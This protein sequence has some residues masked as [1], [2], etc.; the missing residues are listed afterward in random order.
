MTP[1]EVQ[2]AL[3]L[4]LRVGD[5]LLSSGAG[6][7]EVSETI[8]SV[9]DHAGLRRADV[10]VTFTSLRASYQ[11]DPEDMPVSLAR[12]V[13]SRNLDYD[14]LTK[15]YLLVGDFLR[16][17]IGVPEARAQVAR[18]A[19]H[20][21]WVPRWAGTAAAAVFGGSVALLLGAGA[22][23]VLVA[24]VAAVAVTLLQNAMSVR[25]WPVFYVQAACGAL[26]TTIALSATAL[27]VTF[28]DA[29]RPSLVLTASIVLLLA[30]IG[31]LG[32]IQDS[33][34]GFYV[35][36]AARVLEAVLAT[37]GLIA[38]V[39]AGLELAPV[40]GIEFSRITPGRTVAPTIIALAVL[41]GVVAA[42]AFAFICSA[43][44]RALPAV[45]ATALLGQLVAVAVDAPGST[46]PWAAGLAA[47][48]IGAV[49][50]TVAG[51]VRV[52]PLIVVVPALVPLLPGLQI[53]RGMNFIS[54][55]DVE[56][57]LQLSNALATAIA[58]A[59]GALLGE[60]LAAPVKRHG[61]RIERVGARVAAQR[62][63]SFR[64]SRDRG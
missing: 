38:G 58:L 10:D 35:T 13:V 31:F 56:G 47:I 62:K 12:V 22:V 1:R 40:L 33:L 64:A 41:G 51:R 54:S 53:F 19:S 3:D 50:H 4:A 29:L 5:I 16:D 25:E 49:S 42:V 36:S 26:A 46:L 60:Y 63:A 48:A 28:L 30:G 24:A 45:A 27:P 23:V 7:A 15:T 59:A 61:R 21:P 14:E 2:R 6:A 39:G 9:L 57:I 55:G 17:A 18:L 44:I 32:A 8:R 11:S 43:P 34:S 20:S 37:A 52:P